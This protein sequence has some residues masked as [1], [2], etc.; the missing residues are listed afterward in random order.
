MR[1]LSFFFISLI[2][3]LQTQGGFAFKHANNT[4]VVNAPEGVALGDIDGDRVKTEA[5]A[6]EAKRA[7][8]VSVVWRSFGLV[9]APDCLWKNRFFSVATPASSTLT[10]GYLV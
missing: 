2:L 4:L 5:D 6:L 8:S 7:A 9:C 1:V 10:H 3:S